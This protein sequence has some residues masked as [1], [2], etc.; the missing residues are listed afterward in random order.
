MRYTNR[1]ENS[2][3]AALNS[4]LFAKNIFDEQIL[5]NH[6]ILSEVAAIPG[7]FEANQQLT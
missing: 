4:E 7:K 6:L 5:K 3:R 2:L 1:P